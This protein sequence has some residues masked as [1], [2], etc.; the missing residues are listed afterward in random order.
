M[1]IRLS[2]VLL[3]ALAVTACGGNTPPNLSP[4]GKSDFHKTQVVKALD[5]FRDT[6]IDANAQA[7]QLVTTDATRQIVLFHQSALKVIAATDAGWQATVNTLLDETLAKLPP[8][9][10]AKLAPYV[11]LL[12]A[13]LQ[14][15]S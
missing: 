10:S 9:D 8:A 6:A 14:G 4:Q 15:V 2:F 13:V 7:P 5:L 11:A 12:K 3:F 1:K